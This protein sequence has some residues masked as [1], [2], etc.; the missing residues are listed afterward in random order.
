MIWSAMPC[1]IEVVEALMESM[2]SKMR[3][4]SIIL[5]TELERFKYLMR[6][7]IRSRIAKVPS[8]TA[9]WKG[10]HGLTLSIIIRPAQLDKYPLHFLN[11]ESHTSSLSPVEV[12]YTEAHHALL[13]SHYQSSFLAQFPSALQGLSDTTG[14]ISMVQGPDLD[15]AVF[16]RVLSDTS[17]RSVEGTDNS[18]KLNKGDIYIVRW[19]LIKEKVLASEIELI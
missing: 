6:S 18:L 16:C 17:V 12:Q 14:G 11:S 13:S 9:R 5:Q 4:K 1:Q 7:F 8:T 2:D 3:V 10:L 19:R 15:T